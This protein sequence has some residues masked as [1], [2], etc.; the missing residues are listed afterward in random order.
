MELTD[1]AVVRL[2]A[3]LDASSVAA[4]RGALTRAS[5]DGSARAI[6]LRGASP[7]VFCRGLDFAA[8]APGEDPEPAIQTFA[9]SLFAIRTCSKPVLC[10]VDGEAAGGG[11]GVAAAAD[12]VIAT[13]GASFALPELLFGLAPA[14]VLPYLAERVAVQKLRWLA[15]SSERIDACAA[16]QL[17]LVDR[18]MPSEECA[19]AIASW[20]ARLKRARPEAVASW[21][22]MTLTPP[23]IGGTNGVQATLQSLSDTRI[24]DRLRR[25]AEDGE[26]PWTADRS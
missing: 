19:G 8:L 24:G 22:R 3:L 2:P 26:P 14:I 9:A 11:V 10:V 1:A 20:I 6:V 23:P 25:F 15:L 21:K 5:E 17:G 7:G 12:A 13:P 4:M 18:I 16:M